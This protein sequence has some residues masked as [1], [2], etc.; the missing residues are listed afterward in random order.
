[1]LNYIDIEDYVTSIQY[2]NYP[3]AALVTLLALVNGDTFSSISYSAS[4]QFSH[5]QSVYFTVS[6]R[7]LNW[8]S[9]L[10]VI[11]L[12][13]FKLNLNWNWPKYVAHIEIQRM[14]LC[15][16]TMVFKSYSAAAASLLFWLLLWYS[17]KLFTLSYTSTR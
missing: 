14:Y 4:V 8:P 10:I 7:W 3:D 6:I 9:V 12:Y 11:L 2:L 5:S 16:Y 15:Q 13:L 1:M 17:R